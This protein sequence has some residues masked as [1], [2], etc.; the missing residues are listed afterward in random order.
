MTVSDRSFYNG[1]FR[2]AKYKTLGY[3]MRSDEIDNLLK[4]IPADLLMNFLLNR[5]CELIWIYNIDTIQFEHVFIDENKIG[6]TLKDL[7]SFVL[8]EK[9]VPED[10]QRIADLTADCIAKANYEKRHVNIPEFR[11]TH[12]G[13]RGERIPSVM[14]LLIY[15]DE[16]QD[17]ATYIIADTK[18]DYERLYRELL[19]NMLSKREKEYL[20]LYMEKKSPKEICRIM[21]VEPNTVSSYKSSIKVKTGMSSIDDV[22]NIIFNI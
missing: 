4:A 8:R 6:Y 17:H 3:Y 14:N 1:W 9:I 5:A 13:A 18:I 21:D 11:T 7:K 2:P 19:M 10:R 20:E 22:I 12:I 16:S 15:Y